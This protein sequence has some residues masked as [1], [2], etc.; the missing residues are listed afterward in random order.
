MTTA[1][2]TIGYIAPEIFMTNLGNPSHKS[3]VYSYGMLL[4]EMV[5]GKRRFKQMTSCASGN[6]A[7]FPEWIYK[8]VMEEKEIMVQADLIARKMTMV[9]LWCIQM[10]QR[11]RPSMK[12]VVGMLN[13]RVEDIDMPPRPLFMLSPPRRQIFED[14]TNSL[15]SDSSVMALAH[16]Q[17]V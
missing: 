5:S 9:G 10:N 7:Y 4:L 12:R 8:K 15:G 13:G 14:Q 1:R 2:G 6:E 11:D 17:S 16:D 3:D